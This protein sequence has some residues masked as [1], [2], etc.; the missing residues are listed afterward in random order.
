MRRFL[1]VTSSRADYGLF[2]P[3]LRALAD[4]P[5]IDLRVLAMGSHLSPLY[6]S[7]VQTVERD[8]FRIIRLHHLVE[9]GT[10]DCVVD[11][12]ALA[13]QKL[14]AILDAVRP[15]A[16]LVYGDRSELV[17]VALACLLKR[18]PLVHLAGGTVSHGAVDDA[19]RHAITKMA[20]LH[21]TTAE[22]HRRRVIQLGE[23][24]VRVFNF[25]S[26]ILDRIHHLRRM[27]REEVEA[28]V[29]CPLAETILLTF[30]PETLSPLPPERQVAIVLDG[31]AR[32]SARRVLVTG[33]NAD[34]G[35]QAINEQLAA[36]AARAPERFRLVL[37]VGSDLYL[38]LMRFAR[39]MIGN[40]SSG[41]IEAAFFELPVLNIGDRQRG[42]LHAANVAHCRFDPEEI[43][44]GIE[45]VT[46]GAFRAK[47]VG[48][49]NPYLT[50]FAGS[51]A[52]KIRETILTTTFGAEAKAFHDLPVSGW[53]GE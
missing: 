45:L 44:E 15:E 4:E 23:D 29:G 1:A 2:S 27:D 37:N 36:H 49:T 41:I 47:L 40:S 53:D 32:S 11:S 13:L 25:G 31:V 30:H 7:T 12:I 35:G 22:P 18:V 48:L 14:P 34:S 52:Q 50:P 10:D 51:V 33:A 43:R 21:F 6:G 19:I 16:V 8:G 42:R 46:A 20:T 9:G 24:P 28:A 39:A 5:G 38:N 17:A 3:V 26:P